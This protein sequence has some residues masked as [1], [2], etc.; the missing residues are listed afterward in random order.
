MG[1][2]VF[3]RRLTM[4]EKTLFLSALVLLVGSSVAMPGDIEEEGFCIDG[5]VVAG[6]CLGANYAEKVQ[7]T[8]GTC[9]TFC[10][11][12]RENAENGGDAADDR[13]AFFRDFTLLQIGNYVSCED[14]CLFEMF[15]FGNHTDGSINVAAVE[16]FLDMTETGHNMDDN[17]VPENCMEASAD[18]DYRDFFNFY[19]DQA[20]R[21]YYTEE[22]LENAY[23][24]LSEEDKTKLNG[25]VRQMSFHE[26]IK[27]EWSR[28]CERTVNRFVANAA[29]PDAANRREKE[30]IKIK[31]K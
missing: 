8:E 18:A 28:E 29:M 22:M 19:A 14:Q 10:E 12:Y 2:S 3:L 4:R 23:N 27:E 1:D 13:G 30:K 9:R 16:E 17:D 5:D 24:R 31:Y 25:V 15:G 7:T 21:R 6:F 11:E 26:C 20:G